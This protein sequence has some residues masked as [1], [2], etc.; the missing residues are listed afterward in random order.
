MRYIGKR[1][2]N[3]GIGFIFSYIGNLT[4]TGLI[5][6]FVVMGGFSL[7]PF[8]TIVGGG[9]AGYLGSNFGN[10]LAE[11]ILGKDEFK[12]TSAN[13]YYHYI[14]EKYRIP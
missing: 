3:I 9:F 6:G 1:F 12:L 8:I 4:A 13:L 7:A 2:I 10:Y 14:P 11:N 5:Y